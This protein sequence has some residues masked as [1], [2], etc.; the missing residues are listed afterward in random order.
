MGGFYRST[1]PRTGVHAA[2]PAPVLELTMGA[3]RTE[4]E[5]DYLVL[6]AAHETQARTYELQLQ[7][8]R[9]AGLLPQVRRVLVVPDPGGLRIGSGGA[10]L[11]ALERI[12]A[13][14]NGDP[15]APAENVLPRLRVLIVHAGG[16]SIRL[17]AYAPP[18][19]IFVPLPARGDEPLPPALFDRLAPLFLALPPGPPAQGQVVVAAGDALMRWD[20]AALSLAA[21]GITMLAGEASPQEASRHGVLCLGQNNTVSLYLQKPSLEEQDKA[22]AIRP[23]GKTVLDIG[24]MS[25]DGAAAAALLRV[26]RRPETGSSA[27][28]SWLASEWAARGGLDLYREISCALGSKASVEHYVSAVR[29][30][31]SRWPVEELVRVFPALQAIPFHVNVLPHCRFFHF[32]ATRQLIESGLALLAVENRAP[33]PGAI[34]SVNNVTAGSGRILGRQ[35]WVEGCRIHAPLELA[36]SNVV[37]G[38]DVEAPLALPHGA[39]LDVQAGFSRAGGRTWFIRC[40]GIDDNFKNPLS[41]GASLCGAPLAEWITAAGLLPDEVWESSLSGRHRT[42]WNARLFP[43]VPDPS[44]YRLWLWMYDPRR[45]SERQ[46]RNYR[47]AERYSAAEIA[48]LADLEEFSRRRVENWN[49]LRSTQPGPAS[50]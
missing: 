21:P 6:T 41:S 9:K 33:M 26:F 39:C 28:L 32:G 19:K 1:P 12:L 47:Q 16:D 45:A 49:L 40:Y 44:A 15:A 36:G 50:A 27:G 2:C 10:T 38:V 14:E 17:P 23:S 35:A 3:D 43:S 22:G 11:L 24:V 20:P 29:G 37:T 7:L 31:G 30:S 4:R 8:R 46:R 25:M 42:V 34:I 18:G 48:R 13:I 5:W